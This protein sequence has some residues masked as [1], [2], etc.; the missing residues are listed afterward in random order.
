M[1]LTRYL[2]SGA[3]D[4]KDKTCIE[5]GAGTGLPGIFV[6]KVRLSPKVTV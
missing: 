1:L 2:E 4:L 5:I 3:V 6:A